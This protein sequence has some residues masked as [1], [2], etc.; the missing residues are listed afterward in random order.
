MTEIAE[1]VAFVRARLSEREQGADEIHNTADCDLGR[2]QRY[3]ECSC[4]EPARVRQQVAAA[5]A[6]LEEHE[7]VAWGLGHADDGYGDVSPA[8][9]ACGKPEEYARAWPCDTVKA[10]ATIWGAHVDFKPEWTP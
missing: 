5:R 4:G 3:G 9:S 2:L 6:I 1:L 8:C 10:L 7:A